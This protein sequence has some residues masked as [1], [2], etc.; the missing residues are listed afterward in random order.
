MRKYDGSDTTG[1][2]LMQIAG[3]T[4][5]AGICYILSP[6]GSKTDNSVEATQLEIVETDQANEAMGEI[7]S[8]LEKNKT[9]INVLRIRT[10]IF[11]PY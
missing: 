3:V 6:E 5:L 7:D 9:M 1:R 4:T 10:I 11:I 2:L 8:E